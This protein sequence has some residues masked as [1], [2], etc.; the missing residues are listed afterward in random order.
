MKF[1]IYDQF[2]QFSHNKYYVNIGN[3]RICKFVSDEL[4]MMDKIYFK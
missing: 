4:I 1:I 3:Y 2:S